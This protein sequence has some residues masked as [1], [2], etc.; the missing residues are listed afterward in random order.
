M[1]NWQSWF[2]L[3]AALPLA[4]GVHAPSRF[5]ALLA[6]TLGD[7]AGRTVIDA[8]CGAGLITIAA[9]RAGAEHVVAIDADPAA[10]EL[11]RDN[12]ART[13]GDVSPTRLEALQLD[14][15]ELARFDADLL[16]VN[17]PQRP[18]SILQAVEP[19]QRHLHEGGGPDG[20]D[21]LRLVLK[22]TT[23]AIVRTTAA[24]VLPIHT[25]E[26]RTPRRVLTA[27]LPMHLAWHPLTGP[28]APVSVW[29]LHAVRPG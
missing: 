25:V 7:C 1:S 23:A 13:T 24:D 18:E 3:G 17:P 29:D 16:A 2:T 14:F 8:G 19:D 9:L 21:T 5:S 27:T 20:L 15:R 11:T 12:V 26:V 10:V 6:A 28:E 4:P 22:H